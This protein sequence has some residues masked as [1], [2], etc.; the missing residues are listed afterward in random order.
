MIEPIQSS[1][2]STCYANKAL[3]G[4]TLTELKDLKVLYDKDCVFMPCVISAIVDQKQKN[5][6][7]RD[8]GGKRGVLIRDFGVIFNNAV[9]D[10][11]DDIHVPG[12]FG[13]DSL[14]LLE[15]NRCLYLTL[16]I[17]LNINPVVLLFVFGAVM[18]HRLDFDTF[19]STH[20]ERE[21]FEDLFVPSKYVACDIVY[22]CYVKE[23]SPFQ[24]LFVGIIYKADNA[25]EVVSLQVISDPTYD[26]EK[27]TIIVCHNGNGHF[28]SLVDEDVSC[29]NY[30]GTSILQP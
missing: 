12:F 15:R 19:L 22:P 24:V 13:K 5:L 18:K 28:V 30:C 26:E 10:E 20:I 17:L 9:F 1:T 4:L 6:F 3:N 8:V 7:F 27:T 23:M 21:L 11:I 25:I 2:S 16:G 29:V 14:R